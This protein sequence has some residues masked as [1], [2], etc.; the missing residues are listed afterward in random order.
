M[1]FYIVELI[2]IFQLIIIV[3]L[4]YAIEQTGK[5]A[6]VNIYSRMTYPTK[7]FSEC[8]NAFLQTRARVLYRGY[9]AVKQKLAEGERTNNYLVRSDI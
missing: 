9:V 3:F 5:P 1:L 6:G 7:L 2:Q 4:Q 8:C